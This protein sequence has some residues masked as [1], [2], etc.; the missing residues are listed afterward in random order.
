MEKDKAP[1]NQIFLAGM[2]GSTNPKWIG[3]SSFFSWD[4][5]RESG[6]AWFG[7]LII[8]IHHEVS[9]QI[10]HYW[11]S[12]GEAQ[13]IA[14]SGARELNLL[15]TFPSPESEYVPHLLL[16]TGGVGTPHG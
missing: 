14:H 1:P 4:V 3:V 10:M 12:L 13:V 9:T 11:I 15:F 6:C 7:S 8:A 5:A 2:L 16:E